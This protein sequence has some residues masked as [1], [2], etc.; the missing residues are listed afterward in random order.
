MPVEKFPFILWYFKKADVRAT[1]EVQGVHRLRVE[2]KRSEWK[3][4]FATKDTDPEYENE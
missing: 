2:S 4:I 3:M 1:S